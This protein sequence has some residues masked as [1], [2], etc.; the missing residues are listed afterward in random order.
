MA[1]DSD[2]R[3]HDYLR[4]IAQFSRGSLVGIFPEDVLTIMGNRLEKILDF[5]AGVFYIADLE[6]GTVVAKHVMGLDG[7]PLKDLS[8][9]L[10]HKLSGWA[11]A[12]NQALFNLPCFPDFIHH[13]DTG[14]DFQLCSVAPINRDGDVLGALTVYRREAEKFTES[15]FRRLEMIASQTAL[16]LH[17]IRVQLS[18]SGLFDSST[19]LPNA[20]YLHLVFDQLVSDARKGEYSI[21]LIVLRLSRSNADSLTAVKEL[22]LGQLRETDI[23]VRFDSSHIIAVIA[24]TDLNGFNELSRRLKISLNELVASPIETVGSALFPIDG[25]DLESLYHFASCEAVPGARQKMK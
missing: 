21:G 13:P 20:Q 4:S 1:I 3:T 22:L 5:D 24:K 23:L 6:T 11:A 7:A 15:E 25:T 17:R 8:L 16:A 19:S 14:K 12:N 2:P 10:E 18:D 9:S